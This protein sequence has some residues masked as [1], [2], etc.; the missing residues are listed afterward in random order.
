MT[1][2]FATEAQA[3]VAA[4]LS[5]TARRFGQAQFEGY[6][7]LF[8]RAIVLLEEDP[9]RPSSRERS[10]LRQGLRSLALGVAARR[11]SS[12]AHVLYYRQVEDDAGAKTTVVVRV[13]HERMD[14]SR[15]LADAVDA[16]DPPDG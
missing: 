15:H 8:R 2:R 1:V 7:A 6:L 10:D 4:I 13:L 9:F 14:A 12:A 3:D 16:S 11:R 5:E